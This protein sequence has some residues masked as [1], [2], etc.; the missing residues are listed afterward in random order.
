MASFRRVHQFSPFCVAT[1]LQW[2][3]AEFLGADPGHHQDLPAFYAARQDH[4]CTRLAGSR[5]RITPSAGTYF[6]LADQSA[7]SDEDDVAFAL[8][9]AADTLCAI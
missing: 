7:I 8:D 6:Q 4:F 2:A 5:F 9:R 3:L 1:P